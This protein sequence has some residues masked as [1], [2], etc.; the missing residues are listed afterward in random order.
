[1]FVQEFSFGDFIKGIEKNLA[2]KDKGLASEQG[3]YLNTIFKDL[4]S[5]DNGNKSDILEC[6]KEQFKNLVR[7]YALE[8]HIE[9]AGDTVNYNIE[10][11]EQRFAKEIKFLGN[12]DNYWLNI[13]NIVKT[14]LQTDN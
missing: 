6:T 7:H 14:K 8:L 12:D 11:A 1:M 4:A 3:E 10:Q 9:D 2:K 13:R 5:N